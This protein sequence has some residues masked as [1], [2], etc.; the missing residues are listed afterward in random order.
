MAA[1]ECGLEEPFVHI[2]EL[3]NYSVTYRISGLLTEVKWLITARSSLYRSVLDILHRNG[4]EIISPAYMN[5]R[6]MSEDRKIIPVAVRD[7]L[8]EKP[9]IAEDIVFD[10]AEQAVNVEK[11][12]QE[13]IGKIEELESSLKEASEEDKEHIKKRIGEARER[14]KVLEQPATELSLDDPV[15]ELGVRGDCD[16][17]RR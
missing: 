1:R 3:G 7:E 9:V 15:H 13:L 11:E 10:K 16:K 6:I 2:L 4:I 8:S 14:L 12:K 5:Q 17:P